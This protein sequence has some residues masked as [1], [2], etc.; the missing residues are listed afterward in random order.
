MP[1]WYSAN[2]T[3]IEEIVNFNDYKPNDFYLDGF[4]DI[5]DKDSPLYER[6]NLKEL[7]EMGSANVLYKLKTF[8]KTVV[9]YNGNTRVGSKDIFYSLQ[10]IE[11]AKTLADLGIDVDLYWTEDFAHGEVIFNENII[12]E[13]NIAAFVDAPSPIVVYKKLTKEEA[14]NLLYLEYYRGGASDDTLITPDPEDENYFDCNLD[15]VVLNPN[16]AIKYYN[17]YH[18]ALYEDE[19]F[20]YFIPY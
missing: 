17:H 9:Y 3:T 1:T 13:D 7:Y 4:L 19:V 10:D 15:G 14:P 6:M 20:D 16:G 11:N 12:A 18:S 2:N 8:T 5:D